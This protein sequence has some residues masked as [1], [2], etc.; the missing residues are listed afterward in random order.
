MIPHVTPR[1][2][3]LGVELLNED[4]ESHLDII[5]SNHADDNR[6]CC[7]KMLSY[8]LSTNTSAT[9]EKLIEALR[10]SAV[11]LSAV[12]ANLEKMFTGSC[13]VI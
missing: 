6:T 9:W 7:M 8:W 11:E 3:E 4:Q 10:S 12:A 2:F 1:W 5:K 13:I